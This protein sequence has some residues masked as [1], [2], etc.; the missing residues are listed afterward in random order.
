MP[1][2]F[3]RDPD[4]FSVCLAVLTKELKFYHPIHK[5][6]VVEMKAMKDHERQFSRCQTVAL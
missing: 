3:K 1:K 2:Q 6:L 4:I 5:C